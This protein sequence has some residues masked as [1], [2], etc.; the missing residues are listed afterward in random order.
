MPKPRRL[1]FALLLALVL[2]LG[3]CQ[4]LECWA[5]CE[6]FVDVTLTNPKTHAHVTCADIVQNSE[7]SREQRAQ[8]GTCVADRQAEGFVLDRPLPK[9]LAQ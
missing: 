2:P 9:A 8:I 3:G 6:S 1:K 5:L 4:I 7:L